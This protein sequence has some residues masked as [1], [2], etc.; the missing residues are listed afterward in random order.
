MRMSDVTALGRLPDPRCP[1]NR[2]IMALS[3][4][5][6]VAGAIFQS[7]RGAALLE[8]VNWGIGAGLAV[9]LA[10]A[11]GRELDP[12]HDLSAFVGAALWLAAMLFS[13]TPSLMVILW[14]LLVLRLVNRTVGLPAKPLDSLGVLGLGAWLTWQGYW[15]VGLVTAIAF[16]L[17]GL[18]SPPL[19]T[20]LFLSGLAFVATVAL[21][22][23]HGNIAKE[24]G[25]TMPVVIASVAMAG[26]FLL[27]IAT[28]REIQ[29]VGDVT[30]EPLKPKRVQAAQVLALLTAL[31][32]AWWA[33][34][35]G[36]VTLLPLWA[37]MT[38]VGLYRLAILVV[39]RSH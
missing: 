27:V 21:S 14:L 33:G 10:W 37:A 2:A 8:G 19:R 6:V 9:F 39:L 3:L 11:L 12:D 32:F 34:A 35:S 1:T 38:G 5:V 22:I 17:D 36:V 7:L 4:A 26:L 16:L 15:M 31:L 25:P 23:F 18:L 30:G 20:Q 28:S 29:A 13:D 24:G